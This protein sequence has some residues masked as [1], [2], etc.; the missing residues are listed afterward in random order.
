MCMQYVVL[1]SAIARRGGGASAGGL[2][3][4][5][6]D[7]RVGGRGAS[8][9]LSRRC[10]WGL[11]LSFSKTIVR[12]R[13]VR[14]D[15]PARTIVARVR[16]RLLQKVQEFM[17]RRLVVIVSFS[18]YAALVVAAVSAGAPRGLS[19]PPL[20]ALSALHRRRGVRVAVI[21]SPSN[22]AALVAVGYPPRTVT[23]AP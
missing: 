5:R 22:S 19:H 16:G 6:M 12:T 9:G 10:W 3:H 4:S 21:V 15:P 7:T 8:G 23:P 2:V 13:L 11:D 14:N 17:H 1:L 20:N 18:T